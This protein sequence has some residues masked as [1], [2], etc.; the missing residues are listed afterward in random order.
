MNKSEKKFK[1]P[2][3]INKQHISLWKFE[4]RIRKLII[5]MISMFSHCFSI[6]HSLFQAIYFVFIYDIGMS[7]AATSSKCLHKKP[8]KFNEIEFVVVDIIVG[9]FDVWRAV[10]KWKQ[11]FHCICQIENFIFVAFPYGLLVPAIL[12]LSHS[13]SFSY[14]WFCYFFFIFFIRVFV[15]DSISQI[16]CTVL[17]HMWGES[18]ILKSFRAD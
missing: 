17:L 11:F 9:V 3:K 12:C 7:E 16:L 8:N 13:V 18:D 14:D 15:F 10:K 5:Q 1:K 2:K 4:C 6:F